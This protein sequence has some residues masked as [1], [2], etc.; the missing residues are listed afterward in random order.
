[1]RQML[2]KL[3]SVLKI[4]HPQ[5]SEYD[6]FAS[7][8]LDTKAKAGQP[9]SLEKAYSKLRKEFGGKSLQQTRLTAIQKIFETPQSFFDSKTDV[10]LRQKHFFGAI[11][12]DDKIMNEYEIVLLDIKESLIMTGAGKNFI[13]DQIYPL[14]AKKAKKPK[15]FVI[16]RLYPNFESNNNKCFIFYFETSDNLRSE[17]TITENHPLWREFY[18]CPAASIAQQDLLKGV[19]LRQYYRTQC[20]NFLA[21]CAKQP[22]NPTILRY[23]IKKAAE[24]K[25]DISYMLHSVLYTAVEY[26]RTSNVKAILKETADVIIKNFNF[27]ILFHSRDRRDLL[28]GSWRPSTLTTESTLIDI[29]LLFYQYGNSFCLK[30]LNPYFEKLDHTEEKNFLT[31]KKIREVTTLQIFLIGERLE[32]HRLFGIS[33]YENK[34]W[35]NQL[36]ELLSH[37]FHDNPALALIFYEKN[38]VILR[39]ASYDTITNMPH[40]SYIL[41]NSQNEFAIMFLARIINSRQLTT[42]QNKF[43]FEQCLDIRRMDDKFFRIEIQDEIEEQ[44]Y[45]KHLINDIKWIITKFIS[46]SSLALIIIGYAYEPYDKELPRHL[47]EKNFNMASPLRARALT[48]NFIEIV[49][50]NLEDFVQVKPIVSMIIKYAFEDILIA[51]LI[52]KLSDKATYETNSIWQCPAIQQKSGA[53]D[54]GPW[55]AWNTF[56]ILTNKTPFLKID[57][58]KEKE[59]IIS[60]FESEFK[61]LGNFSSNNC[62]T[63]LEQI[64]EQAFQPNSKLESIFPGLNKKIHQLQENT[65]IP[66]YTLINIAISD[67]EYRLSKNYIFNNSLPHLKLKIVTNFLLLSQMR[68]RNMVHFILVEMEGHW[69][70]QMLTFHGLSKKHISFLRIDSGHTPVAILQRTKAHLI[71]LIENTSEYAAQ[72]AQETLPKLHQELVILSKQAFSKEQKNKLLK[73]CITITQ[74]FSALAA[75]SKSQ[76]ANTSIILEMMNTF[77]YILKL[78]H[79]LSGQRK[80]SPKWLPIFKELSFFHQLYAKENQQFPV[81]QKFS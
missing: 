29:T 55:A 15:C 67:D 78:A 3:T 48:H 53:S 51:S 6:K 58:E 23:L 5:E 74:F 66:P 22:N 26:Q 41:Q 81:L 39:E 36:V 63:E 43:S 52:K 33:S 27:L 62:T 49:S 44:Q 11:A 14:A 1:M 8:I 28:N 75:F 77:S 42:L 9:Y 47:I 80:N 79:R 72:I 46:A 19:A 18:T 13:P 32:W 65:S 31:T 60:K 12:V 54:S 37:I 24:L 50:R 20:Q 25:I 57:D 17:Y 71:D 59:S 4:Q 10:A 73:Y 2:E 34:Y 69:H 61:A 7:A 21:L 30:M 45:L 70:L 56:K 64:F 38:P 40:L 68:H 76:P 16:A 35:A